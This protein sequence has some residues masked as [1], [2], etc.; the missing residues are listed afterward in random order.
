MYQ[1]FKLVKMTFNTIADF[2]T[3]LSGYTPSPQTYNESLLVRDLLA[4]LIQVAVALYPNT[5]FSSMSVC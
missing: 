3:E 1:T 5:R 2:Q 4:V